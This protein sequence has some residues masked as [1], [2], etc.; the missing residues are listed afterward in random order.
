MRMVTRST[1]AV[2]TLALGLASL[3]TAQQ[4][5]ELRNGDRLSGQLASIRGGSWLFKH[6]GGEI[7]VPVADVAGFTASEAIG[8][9][10]IDGAIVAATVTTS[11]GLLQLTLTD[12]SSRIVALSDFAAVGDPGDLESLRPV[13]IGYFR[14][15]SKFWGATIAFGFA[16]NS[17]NSRSRGVTFSFDIERKSPKDRQQ[18]KGGL[19]R[20]FA[21]GESGDL[22]T[23]VEKY[24]GSV[25]LDLF[26]SSRLFA[27][28]FG[29][30]NRD[31]FQDLDLR[32]NYTVGLGYQLIDTDIT[33]LRFYGSG[34]ARI[35]NYTSGGDESTGIVALAGEFKQ[36]LGPALF[37]W[38]LSW[39]PSVEDVEDYRIL[40]DASITTT[41]FEGLGFRIGS[42]NEYN[43]NPRPGIDKHDWLFTTALT[44]TVG[45]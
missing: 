6:V 9:R 30:W 17:G 12:G 24:Y 43:N 37:D 18:I 22:E 7:S 11:G 34:G 16:N 27:F 4:T 21:P 2:V 10:L 15:F 33:D 31:R 42:R 25:R 14:P 13:A 45:R 32:S 39:A 41:I 19:S 26:V 36:K 8:L 38:A 28:G 29:G 23:T 20:E 1:F 40:S 3:A 44:Y 5:L 35:E